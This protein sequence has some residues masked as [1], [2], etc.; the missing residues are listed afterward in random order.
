MKTKIKR[1]SRSVLSVILAISMLISCMMVGLIASDAAKVTDGD[2]PLGYSGAT[3]YYKKSNSGTWSSASRIGMTMSNNNNTGTQT[4]TLDAS[5]TYYFVIVADNNDWWGNNTF[6]LSGQTSK[7]TNM[8]SY[9]NFSTGNNISQNPNTLQTSTSGSYTFSITL[10]S[11]SC[12]VSGGSGGSGG[13]CS[14]NKTYRLV[15]TAGIANNAWSNTDTNNNFTYDASIGCYK[16]TYTNVAAGTNDFRIIEGSTWSQNWGFSQANDKVDESNIVTAWSV[17]PDPNGDN[18]IHMT[19]N[20]KANVEIRLDDSKSSSTTPK[21]ITVIVTP[22]IITVNAGHA[23]VNNS[24]NNDAG[25]ITVNDGSS[26][27]NITSGGTVTAKAVANYHWHFV[28]WREAE[29]LTFDNSN[30]ATA[31]VTVIGSATLNANF[32]KDKYTVTKVNG[33]NSTVSTDKTSVEWGDTVTVTTTPASGYSVTGVTCTYVDGG[34]TQTVPVTNT[35]TN[36]YTFTMP[37]YNVTVTSADERL[38]NNTVTFGVNDGNK[39]YVSVGKQHGDTQNQIEESYTSP[40]EHV[41]EGTKINFCAIPKKN[42][43]F[44]G[45]YTNSGCTTAASASLFTTGSQ[46]TKDVTVTMPATAVT[47][48]A[49]FELDSNLATSGVF[50]WIPSMLNGKFGSGTEVIVVLPDIHELVTHHMMRDRS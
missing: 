9:S 10:S 45:W 34:V 31:T 3:L 6:N 2:E 22:A 4:V 12:T 50:L 1:H 32:A 35:G 8:A 19:T 42:Y 43:K 21:A 15:G 11:G 7:T 29:G 18:N 27:T 36:T 14:T 24:E 16:K 28:S 13:S 46:T 47:L 20:A 5:S 49:K 39:G 37:Q 17:K 30:R 38:A 40:E 23:Y 48:Y 44:V 26:V 41:I 25:S 33:S